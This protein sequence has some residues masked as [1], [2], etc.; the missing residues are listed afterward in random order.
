MGERVGQI[1]KVPEVKQSNS[2]SRVRRTKRLQS[3]DTPVDRI[4]YLQRTVGNQAVSRLMRSGALQAKLRIGQPNDIYEQEADRVA[5]AVMRMPEPGVQRQVEPEEEL[6]QGKIL[7]TVQRQPEEEEEE[8]M[9]KPVDEHSGIRGS[10]T[11]PDLETSIQQV[12]GRGQ[13]LSNNTRVPME[14]AFGTDFSGVRVH[15]DTESDKLNN[16]LQARAFTTGQDIFFKEGEY[17]PG[18]ASGR[19]L[20]A[21]ELTHVLQ[22]KKGMLQCNNDNN[23]T[24]NVKQG[25][26]LS[27]IA[28]KFSIELK[29]LKAANPSV[30]PKRLRIG[31]VLIIPSP[32][33]ETAKA[34]ESKKPSAKA[35][36]KPVKKK[37]A[38]TKLKY[39]V[40]NGDSL[41]KIAKKFG[42]TVEQL[43]KDNKLKSSTIR[44][45]D[46][47]TIS[48]KIACTIK[49]PASA[50]QQLL[51]GTIFA[52]AVAGRI[53]NDERK[54]IGW[55]FINSVE[56]TVS[57]CD[58]TICT[59]LKK[60]QRTFL[61]DRDTKDLGKTLVDAI[62][63]GSKAYN[64][65]RWK[66][67][68]AGN[69]ML[70][71]GNLCLLNTQEKGALVRA[72]DAA[73]EVLAGKDKKAAIMRFNKAANSPPSTR[74]EKSER[75][76]AHTF[77]KFKAG[78]KCGEWK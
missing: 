68:M 77:Y 75:I 30:V 51:G 69:G 7:E 31:Q 10:T 28:R 6:I 63:K 33:K 17:N 73:G 25:D 16:S 8:L 37:T 1:T 78:K 64:N 65:N 35:K 18:S 47:L 46:V 12:R 53:P 4:L 60:H 15:A 3:M 66:K 71:L 23:K 20:L 48:T 58:G 14:Q 67:V 24:Y 74:L 61:C 52:E 45:G 5:D 19:K 21:H 44:T 41:S 9:A 39:K 34:G 55:A 11:T 27:S 29:D 40:V 54:A 76:G 57:L 62:K 43:K 49:R 50:R 72:I 22:Q 42:T 13:P 56:H 38:S 59:T 70:P 32:G 36:S 26:T 2:N